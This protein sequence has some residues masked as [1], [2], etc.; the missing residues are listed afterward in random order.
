MGKSKQEQFPTENS[1]STFDW[2]RCWIE[3]AD[4]SMVPKFKIFH[5]FL[6]LR[7]LYVH[8]FGCLYTDQEVVL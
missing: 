4:W 3:A 2:L 7:H 6:K 5:G 8:V 1:S